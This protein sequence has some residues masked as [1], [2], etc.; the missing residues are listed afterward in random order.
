MKLKVGDI[1]RVEG[2]VMLEGLEEGR[3]RV[4]IVGQRYGN[5]TYTFCRPKGNKAV[6]R[7]YAHKVDAWLRPTDHPDRNKIVQ[8]DQHKDTMSS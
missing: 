1:V 6:C 4:A 7:H 2:W 8:E 3:Y 5:D